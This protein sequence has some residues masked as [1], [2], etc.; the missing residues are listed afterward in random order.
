MKMAK[1][2]H[3]QINR[4]K[5]AILTNETNEER[6]RRIEWLEE[7]KANAPDN[8]NFWDELLKAVKNP[9]GKKLENYL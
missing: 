2:Y 8:A 7:Q 9:S 5:V 3:N 6:Q 4:I 1:K